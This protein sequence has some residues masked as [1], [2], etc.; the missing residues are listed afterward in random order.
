MSRIA[1]EGVEKRFDQVVALHAL[2]LDV[3]D[4]SFLVL[5]GAFG[6]R[7]DA[8][9]CESSPASRR[10]RRPRLH[11][12]A[13][14]H[15]A[16]AARPRRRHGVPELRALPA[17]DDPGQHRV[18][19]CRLREVPEA[20]RTGRVGGRGES[21]EV[22]HLLDRKPRQ[23][24]GG[25]RQRIALARAIVRDPRLPHGRAALEPRRTAALTMR[26]EIKRLQQRLGTTTHVRHARPGRGA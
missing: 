23:L 3:A 9:H 14:R 24:S 21:L 17:H 4:G 16:A 22:E 25:Q 8:P 2:D 19:R 26:G 12:R 13:R 20:E 6:L 10:R 5:L 18:S 1:F 7:Q 11:R 15:A